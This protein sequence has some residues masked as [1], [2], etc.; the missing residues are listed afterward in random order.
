MKTK[1]L[2][3]YLAVITFVLGT[4]SLYFKVLRMPLMALMLLGIIL[5]FLYEYKII[6]ISNLHIVIGITAF[7]LLDT[8]IKREN[9]IHYNDL[10]IWLANSIFIMTLASNMEF[11]DFKRKYVI[12]MTAEAIIS[13]TCFLW[14]DVMGKS[15]PLLSF[16]HMSNTTGFYLTP[17]FTRGWGNVP[18]FHRNA[19]MFNEPGMHQVFLNFSLFLLLNDINHLEMGKKQYRISLIMLFVAVLTTMSTTG[20]LCL[21]IVITSM[22]F[23]SGKV[24]SNWK[25][26]FGMICLIVALFIVEQQTGVVSHK[27]DGFS[28]G[29]GSAQT[30]YN[31]TF[32]G[33]MIAMKNPIFGQGIFATN[34]QSVLSQY[35]IKNISNGMASYAIRAGVIA[36]IIM[37]VLLYKGIIRNMP[38]GKMNN[39]L[40]FIFVLV[41]VNTEGC[42]MNL[43]M[44]A[45]IFKW[46]VSE[47]EVQ[48]NG[49][50]RNDLV[51]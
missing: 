15:L 16:E 47:R 37:L 46:K 18:V 1:N 5:L 6:K 11:K 44:L 51:K 14:S 21:L 36:T 38:Y 41:C 32:Y 34:V 40:L 10:I 39:L 26:Q 8:L 31:D 2:T 20:Y 25:L 19:G 50:K 29:D 33:Y 3:E 30:R 23:R 45:L 48:Y 9:G 22:L 24:K 27:L 42:F 12:I 49:V 13:L 17:Y 4:G 28:G 35:G 43:F 7:Y